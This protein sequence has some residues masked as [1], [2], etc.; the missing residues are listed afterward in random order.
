V[1]LGAFLALR[2]Y[3]R[4]PAP[5]GAWL[6]KAGLEERFATI[7]GHRVRYVRTGRGPAVLLLHGFGSSLYTW[8]DVIPALAAERE[9]VALD[10]PGFGWSDLP[11]D[12][13]FEVFPR[14]ALGL[15]DELGLARAS[16]VGNSMGG[17]VASLVAAEHPSRVDHLVLVDAAGFNLRERDRP[18]LVRL[19]THPWAEPLMNALPLRRL[20]VER[21]LAQVFHD[22]AKVGSERVEEYL[23][24]ASRPGSLAGLRSLGASVRTPPEEF[25]ATLGRI[26]APTL[27]IW[28]AEDAWI[29]SAHGERFAAAIARARLERLPGVGHVPQEEDPA[30]VSRLVRAF[31]AEGPSS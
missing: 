24:A 29:P 16:L 25:E 18:R 28:G 8:K 7:G 5:P 27:V 12:L 30:S 6:R 2:A 13:S 22:A 17:A 21:G 23:A 19:A 3:D 10:F 11:P 9:V 1:A 26:Q 31:L 14:V 20:V 4:P 15:L